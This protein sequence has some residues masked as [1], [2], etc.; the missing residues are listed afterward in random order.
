MKKILLIICLLFINPVFSIE[1]TALNAADK[2]EYMNLNWWE[3]FHDEYLNTHL[4][5]LYEKNY[6]LQNAALKVKENEQMVKMQFANELPSLNLSG[7]INRDFQAPR[8]L[9]GDMEIPKYSQN[10]YYL[11]LTA[12]YEIDIWGKNRLYTKSKKEQ[13]E[14][15]KQAERAT[16]I[17]LSAAFAVDYFNLIK[18]DRLI[19]IQD[20]LIKLQ[21]DIVSKT[22]AKYKAGLCSVNE[23]LGQEK[24]LTLLKEEYN[25]HLQA[26]EVLINS[27]KVYL[28]KSDKEIERNNYKNVMPLTG[29]PSEYNSA[30]VENRPDYL[31]EEAN[32]K[33][34]GFDVRAAK[35]EFLPSFTIFGQIGLNA[36]TL[37]SLF[38]S[39]S[40]MLSAGILP[41]ID[42]FSGGRK[43]AFLK[44]KKLEYEEAL[45]NY[46]KAYL[47]GVKEVNSSLVEYKTS[48]KNYDETKKRIVLEDK[49]YSLAKDKKQIGAAS[50]L[51]VLFAKQLYLITQKEEASSKIN[52]LIAVIGLYKAAGGVNLYQIE[53]L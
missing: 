16:Y 8:E 7:N 11:P 18:A 25:I 40:R 43:R 30:I 26:R 4:L 2:M 24:F 1:D 9:F 41:D 34:T 3:N 6:D 33:R 22:L 19:E 15:V 46:Q 5:T 50:D 38:S 39:P 44:M 47:T 23:L 28:V 20:E 29:V 52:S 51:D 12:E 31:F 48:V 53:K 14:A 49:I 27:I 35:R 32:L 37:G 13:L 10:N 42:L 36:Y 45:N 17:S 21:E